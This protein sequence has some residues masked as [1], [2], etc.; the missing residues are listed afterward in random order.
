VSRCRRC[1]IPWSAQ[2]WRQV[3][4]FL[5]SRGFQ[6]W[7]VCARHDDSGEL[8]GLTELLL[9]TLWPDVAFQ[10]DTGVWPKHRDRGLGRWLKATMCRL[11]GAAVN[12]RRQL[13]MA[14]EDAVPPAPPQVVSSRYHEKDTPDGT[15]GRVLAV[16][17]IDGRGRP[18]RTEVMVFRENRYHFKAINA[19]YWS[20]FRIFEGNT[21]TTPADPSPG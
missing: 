16:A 6:W 17:G 20:N 13:N 9:P 14:G 1:P 12:C 19:V 10:E 11:N 21:V 4:E 5:A 2:Q 7:T 3:E 8:A 18:Y 15:P